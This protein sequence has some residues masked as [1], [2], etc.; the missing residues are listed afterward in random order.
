MKLIVHD[1]AA[2][3]GGI[4]ARPLPERAEALSGLIGPMLAAM[5]FL[6]TGDLAAFHH[7]GSGFRVDRDD[8]RYPAALHRLRAA[9]VWERVEAEVTRAWEHQRAAVPGIRAAEEVN[10]VLVLGDPD[11]DWL[12]GHNR[13]LFGMGAIPGWIHLTVWPTDD[14]IDL[15]AHCAVHEFNHNVRY[16]NVVWNPATVELGEQ[17]VSE[18]LA[19]AFVRELSGES[20]L[21]PW[22]TAL[23]PEDFDHAYRTI[24]AALGLTGMA[25]FSAY[26]HGD[27]SARRMGAEPVG[28]PDMA[29]Y[30]VGLAIVDAHL[31]ATGLTA[32]ASTALPSKEIIAN[33]GLL[34]GSR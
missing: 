25:N 29:G 1:T 28:L 15:I 31:K 7:R 24:T 9:G 33:A 4:L 5:P 26:V 32:A 16:A 27:T 2:T 22:A 12:I 6:G 19:D 13:G 17:I 11:D 8:D 18:G 34:P 3:I 30:P 23:R 21:G 10:V 14:N 20:A